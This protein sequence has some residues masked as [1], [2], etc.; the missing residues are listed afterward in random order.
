M[1]LPIVF[2][3]LIC[4]GVYYS[5]KLSRGVKW[6]EPIRSTPDRQALRTRIAQM[7]VIQEWAET[8]WRERQMTD[9][10][11]K[12]VTQVCEKTMAGLEKEMNEDG[13]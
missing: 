13:V 2:I 10:T 11:Y 9:A 5:W 6:D 8:A 4:G 1:F 3:I 7:R 12:E